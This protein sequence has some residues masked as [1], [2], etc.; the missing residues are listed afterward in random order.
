MPFSIRP[1]RRFPVQ[2]AVTYNA[3]PF[4]KL[5]LAYFSGFWLLITL[6]VLSSSLAFAEWVKH[7]PPKVEQLCTPIQTPFTAKGIW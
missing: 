5:P 2:C 4:H 6:L 1:Y 7:G 3:G